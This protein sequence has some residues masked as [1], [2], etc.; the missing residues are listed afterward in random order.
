[1]TM[2]E[3]WMAWRG[4][5]IS[6]VMGLFFFVF[7]FLRL[8]FPFPLKLCSF[9]YSNW[10]FMSSYVRLN[11]PTEVFSKTEASLDE[12]PWPEPEWDDPGLSGF[13][14]L[15]PIHWIDKLKILACKCPQHRHHSVVPAD[16]WQWDAAGRAP[17]SIRRSLVALLAQLRPFLFHFIF[18]SFYHYS[19][20]LG[21]RLSGP[22]FFFF[23]F[24][25]FLVLPLS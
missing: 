18:Y 2:A 4:F 11:R 21:I 10:S 5:A 19:L 13:G 24:P 16:Y 8:P 25:L 1:M 9:F 17:T 20:C 6:W 22:F 7:R 3:K 23:L 14:K 12:G 15:R